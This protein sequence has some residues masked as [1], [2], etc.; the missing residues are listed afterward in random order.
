MGCVNASW[1]RR[2]RRSPYRLFGSAD[3]EI[4][5][6]REE[7]DAEIGVPR[8]EADTEIGVPRESADTEIGVPK[9]ARVLLT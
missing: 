5:V 4:G 7:A 9:I 2:E 3:T 1:E 6:P 8:E